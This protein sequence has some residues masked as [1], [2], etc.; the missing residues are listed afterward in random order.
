MRG[1]FLFI[2]L[3]ISAI[4]SA[5]GLDTIAL[6]ELEVSETRETRPLTRLQQQV[7]VLSPV[8]LEQLQISS[9]KDVSRIVPNVMMPD[10][11]SA[12]T[13][14]IYIRGLGSRIDQ[15][16]L[17]VVVDG[18]PLLDKNGFD[19]QLQ[20][21]RRM[22]FLRG[23]QGSL[24]GRNT[25]GGILDIH[26]FQPLDFQHQQINASLTY[27]TTNQVDAQAAIYRNE[28]DKFGWS[29]LTRYK[30]SDGFYRNQYSN[31]LIDGS[32]QAGGQFSLDFRPNRFW[33]VANNLSVDW[34]DQG[35]FPYENQET[36]VICYNDEGS[37]RRFIVRNALRADY[38]RDGYHLQLSA[39]YQYLH[40]RMRMDQ[41]YT[42]RAIFTLE[43]RQRQQGATVDAL[44]EG[45]KLKPWYSWQVGISTFMKRNR[46]EAPVTFKREGLDSLILY[47]ANQGLQRGGLDY[48]LD[49]DD[50]TM[51]IDDDFVLWNLGAAVYH[52]S[53]FQVRHWQFTLGLRL[54]MEQVHMNYDAGT[55]VQYSI[56]GSNNWSKTAIPFS[57]QL[58]G[59][60]HNTYWQVMPKLAVSYESEHNTVYAYAAKGTKAGGYNTQIFSTVVQ[61]QLMY[62]LPKQSFGVVL[63]NLDERFR[64]VDITTYKPEIAWTYEIGDHWN[65]APGL[66]IDADVFFIHCKD[67]QVTVFPGGKTTGRMMANAAGA[68]S[69]GGEVTINY[70][71]VSNN[72][73]GELMGTYGYTDARFTNFND[74]KGDYSGKHIPYAPVHTLHGAA[75][76]RYVVGK[77]WLQAFSV[78][79][80]GNGIGPIYW[81]ERNDC[82]QGM[83][84]L[85]NAQ[86]GFS[87]TRWQL[88]LWGRNLT[89]TRYSVFYFESMEKQFLQRGKPAEIGVSMKL[90]I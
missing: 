17:G 32:Q 64:D 79:I 15:P 56:Y 41:D 42:D 33:R 25:M 72:W 85:L 4:L 6:P 82:K 65:P 37:Y 74:G 1:T 87:W 47:N 43:Q 50:P 48:R 14:S 89:Q 38:Q 53:M 39:S 55:S 57:T 36:G 46:Q 19:F 3:L 60:R 34:V 73:S 59:Y 7:S 70:R 63:E 52:Q 58:Q 30:R 5:E 40:D 26:T 90:S 27:G 8:Q 69:L 24:Y 21:I 51:Q 16:V 76:L 67:Q 44:L 75:S 77:K 61:N 88:Q 2:L 29:L 68:R 23:P 13:S 62:D 66:Q 45:P 71:W 80:Q 31:T 35:A 49:I 28:N 10:Y 54:D 20:G 84:G 83:Y 78:T 9:P 18:V 12:M 22:E 11:G 81:N 86:F